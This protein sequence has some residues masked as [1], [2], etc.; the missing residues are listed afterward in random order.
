[1]AWDILILKV[2][3]FREYVRFGSNKLIKFLKKLLI[4]AESDSARPS[5]ALLKR[6]SRLIRHRKRYVA[7]S[8]EQRPVQKWILAA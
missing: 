6:R 5:T 3:H 8:N 7:D 4:F 1:M 2:I